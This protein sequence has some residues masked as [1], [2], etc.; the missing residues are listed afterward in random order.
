MR[1]LIYF[2]LSITL[3]STL[4]AQTADLSIFKNASP[5]PVA[6]GAGL[7]YSI[8]LSNEGPDASN[9]T[10]DDPL[11]PGTTFQSLNAPAGWSCT[12]PAA[13]ANGTAHCSIPMLA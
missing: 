1:K 8:T 4:L 11:P 2:S 7:T 6:P 9:A 12:M 3:A 13:G 10:L 5:N